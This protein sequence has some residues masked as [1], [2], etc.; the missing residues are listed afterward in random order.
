MAKINLNKENTNP[1]N[2]YTE[3][4]PKLPYLGK[5]VKKLITFV[6]GIKYEFLIQANKNHGICNIVS[7]D[8][9]NN[10]LHRMS[11]TLSHFQGRQYDDPNILF[12][13][14]NYI[15]EHILQD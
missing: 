7:I 8:R 1:K 13:I 9:L 3:I 6:D 5:R 12:K 4:K 11:E 15:R 10:K 2:S 14:E